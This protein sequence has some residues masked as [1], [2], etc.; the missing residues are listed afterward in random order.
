MSV[1]ECQLLLSLRLAPRSLQY[2]QGGVIRTEQKTP[3]TYL[4]AKSRKGD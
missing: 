4:Q 2:L 1:S 3:A